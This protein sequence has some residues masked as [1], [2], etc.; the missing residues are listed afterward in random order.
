M[1]KFLLICS[2]FS[3]LHASGQN[4]GDVQSLSIA[5][6]NQIAS[7]LPLLDTA[8]KHEDLLA[9]DTLS[10]DLI[11]AFGTEA[12]QPD[13][14]E[15]YY[16]LNPTT[17]W[18]DLNNSIL[19]S[20]MLIAA[21]SMVYVE[22][23]KAAK[24]MA[25]PSYQPHSLF[26]RASAEIASGLLKIA[27]YETDLNRKTQYTLWA[28]KALD[29]LASMQLPSG[30][31]PFPDLRD[32]GD[33]T[34]GPIIQNFLNSCGPDS[35]NVLQNG[36]I[37]DD[38]NTGEFKFDC[39]V[40]ANAYYEAYLYTGNSQY[41]N[42]AIGIADYIMPLHFNVNYNY[43]TFASLA[44]TRAYELTGDLN[45]LQRAIATLRYSLAP[46]QLQNGRWVDG[47][48]ANSRYHSIILQNIQA[49][50]NALPATD[51]FKPRLDS[52]T[53][54]AVRNMNTYTWNCES[55]TGFRWAMK[56]WL[57]DSAVLP[58]T[59]KDSVEQL[60]GR[61]IHEAANSGKYLDVP[62]MGEY[63]EL[64]DQANGILFDDTTD[65]VRLELFPNPTQNTSTLLI[66]INQM[67]DILMLVTDITGKQIIGSSSNS[68]FPGIH[69]LE[70]DLSNFA[71]GVYL[72]FVKAGDVVLQ[73]KLILS[74]N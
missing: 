14:T 46:G 49:T 39:G 68:V 40:I 22:L 25:P 34:F 10:L 23:W 18:L 9:I 47:H 32:Y 63:L 2:L 31:F 33:P 43:N 60:I 62:S 65:E 1:K 8:L 51:P 28:T 66:H 29:S 56:S 36:W 38:K 24:G 64:L 5:Q 53:V 35:V 59:L 11:A 17:N 61:H 73:K 37:V 74:R 4:C 20:R 3:T 26:L 27:H 50:V 13:A 55:A 45:Y 12:G 21:D 52:M 41:K 19:L 70:L 42:I 15:L 67:Q 69:S 71:S 16:A 58:G 6:E 30:A 57:L 72:V 48:N 7:I 44:L 54:S